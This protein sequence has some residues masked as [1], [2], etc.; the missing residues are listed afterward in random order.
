[1]MDGSNGKAAESTFKQFNQIASDK[2]IK[3]ITKQLQ[4]PIKLNGHSL[5]ENQVSKSEFYPKESV[6]P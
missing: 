2:K 6:T 3:D 4:A 5:K 1:M